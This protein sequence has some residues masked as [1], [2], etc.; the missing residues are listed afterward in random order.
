MILHQMF[1]VIAAI[2]IVVVL[3]ICGAVNF[4]KWLHTKPSERPE[5]RGGG[6]GGLTGALMMGVDQLVRP[7]A[8][9][10]I[11]AENPIV[12]EDEQDGE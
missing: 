2:L 4:Y 1:L 7:S 12:K 3:P 6:T 5:Q 8:E 10:R 9:H 11:E